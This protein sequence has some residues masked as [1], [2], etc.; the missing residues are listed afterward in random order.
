MGADFERPSFCGSGGAAFSAGRD[1]WETPMELFRRLDRF[2]HFD[3]DAAASDSNHLCA[4]YYTKE[5]DGLAHSW[6][7]R[8][9]WCNPPYGRQIADWC[10][11]AYEDTRDGTTVV[12]MLIPAR[13]DTGWYHDYIEGKAAEVKFLRGRLKFAL[14]GGRSEQRPVPVDARE[15]GW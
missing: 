2:W 6:K 5:T 10:R 3:L 9:V 13:T 11:K 7:G 14:G 8:R 15:M 4:D 1:D 12:I